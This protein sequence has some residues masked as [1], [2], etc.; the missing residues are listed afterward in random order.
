MSTSLPVLA[1]RARSLDDGRSPC[2]SGVM[3]TEN[4]HTDVHSDKNPHSADEW[5]A[6]YRDAGKLWTSDVNPAL[7]VEVSDLEPGTALEVGSGEGADARWLAD[8]GWQ[9]IALDISQVA[10]D[11]A[12]EI[13]PREAITWVR[14]DLTADDVPGRDFGL[15]TAHYFPI[16]ATD[17]HVARKLID[18]V[19][20]GGTLLVVAHAP[21]G[22]RA[23]GFD[24]DDYV[25]PGDIAKML[26]DGW[27]IHT[28]ET[29]ERGR[30]AGGGHHINDVVLRAQRS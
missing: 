18:A 13:D 17:V 15:V 8:Q 25:Q 6:R 30:P 26:G 3:T 29:R 9:V 22:V 4:H 1:E 27:T 19:G 21:E 14:A 16:K 23:H 2:H 24:P 5:D 7:P 12:R 11:R 28:H 10:I 20:P